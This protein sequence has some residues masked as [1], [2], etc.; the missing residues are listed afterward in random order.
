[1]GNERWATGYVT[2][3][4]SLDKFLYTYDCPDPDL[5]GRLFGSSTCCRQFEVTNNGGVGLVSR[6][7]AGKL[8][9]KS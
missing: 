1:M 3:K 4:P 9:E 6:I 8:R 5:I 2:G 7:H